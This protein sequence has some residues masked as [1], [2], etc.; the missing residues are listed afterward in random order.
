MVRV[1]ISPSYGSPETRR[2]WAD[3][4]DQ[5]VSF[6]ER[7]LDEQLTTRQRR[8]LIECHPEGRARFWGAT[9]T[10]DAR[11]ADVARGDIVFF[12]GQN[13]VRAVGEVGVIFR[14]REFADLMWPPTPDGRS[15]H[16]VYSLLDLVPAEFPYQDLNR[17]L[18]Y[19]EAHTFPGQMVVRGERA[20]KVLDEFMITPGTGEVEPGETPPSPSEEMPPASARVVPLEEGRTR[21]ADYHRSGRLV[22]VERRE[23]QLVAEYRRHLETQGRHPSRYRCSAG[24]SDIY[25]P[26]AKEPELIEAKSQAGH[27]HVRE[28]LGQLLDYA[29]HSPLP[30]A[31]LA[32]LFPVR[33]AAADTALLHRYGIDVIHR[34]APEGFQRLP[35]PDENRS[36]MRRAWGAGSADRT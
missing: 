4:V 20:R 6:T 7:R 24:V 21:R 5:E 3:T 36:L 10:H 1:L 16:I 15:W 29:P 19:K 32:G 31:R 35:A 34:E 26:D 13:R 11:M 9:A 22:V 28:A 2:H 27:H 18:G 25:L 30:L 12:T 17:V 23:S 14:N 8:S 33:P